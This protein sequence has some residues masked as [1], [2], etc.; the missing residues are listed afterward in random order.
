MAVLSLPIVQISFAKTKHKD[1]RTLA[2]TCHPVD[3]ACKSHY[4][5]SSVAPLCRQATTLE[6]RT[7][8]M[9]P[10]RAED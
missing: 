4:N 6:S 8:G 9:K 1:M 5:Q 10:I 2:V 3:I 7:K